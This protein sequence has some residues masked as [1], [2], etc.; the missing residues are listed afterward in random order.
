M[1]VGCYVIGGLLL[2]T[3]LALCLAERRRPHG[4]TPALDG[5]CLAALYRAA[6]EDQ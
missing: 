2:A 1:I 3:S 6:K 4:P 5:H